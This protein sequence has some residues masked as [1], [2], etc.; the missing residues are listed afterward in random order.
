MLSCC[1]PTFLINVVVVLVLFSLVFVGD[2]DDALV[3]AWMIPTDSTI[4]THPQ[5][6]FSSSSSSS[7]S[8][9]QISS[10][11]EDGRRIRQPHLHNIVHIRHRIVIPLLSSTTT[12]TSFMSVLHVEEN[13]ADQVM[14]VDRPTSSSSLA[15]TSITS[16]TATVAATTAL[17]PSNTVETLN[18]LLHQSDD[19]AD[20]GEIDSSNLLPRVTIITTPSSTSSL[21]PPSVSSSSSSEL[22]IWA[23]R[24][25]LLLVAAIWGT[26]FA[27]RCW[28]I[29]LYSMCFFCCYFFVI[30]S[31]SC[32]FTCVCSVLI[33][34]VF[35]LLDV[36]ITLFMNTII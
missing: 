36:F 4:L 18:S 1:F 6:I 21:S 23:A 16:T 32:S 30:A 31:I 12:T 7:S 28:H 5:R 25:I 20:D 33:F 11:Y 29:E 26:N 13:S 17:V 8:S 19:Y 14:V 34:F 15:L 10:L 35:C 2:G 24:G 22:G 27:V 3:V 9:S